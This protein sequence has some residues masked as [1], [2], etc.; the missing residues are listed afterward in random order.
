MQQVFTAEYLSPT[1]SV[2]SCLRA[3]MAS[4]TPWVPGRKFAMMGVEGSGHHLLQFLNKRVNGLPTADAP[5]G[6]HSFPE[7]APH[8]VDP[9]AKPWNPPCKWLLA[10]GK[11]IVLLRDPLDSLTSGIA[12]YHVNSTIE[13][14]VAAHLTSYEAMH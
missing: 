2:Q 3:Q 9:P 12:S 14:M 5:A 13:Q 4:P 10:V 6:F 8:H 1:S 7:F 11:F